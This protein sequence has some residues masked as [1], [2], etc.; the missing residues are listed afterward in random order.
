MEMRKLWWIAV[1]A[2]AIVVVLSSHW[3]SA[4]RQFQTRQAQAKVQYELAQRRL[5]ETRTEKGRREYVLEVIGLGVTVEKYRQGK[6]WDVLQKGTPYS[7]IREKDPHKY[8]WTGIDKDQTTG[9]RVGDTLENGA[10]ASPDCWGVPVF[11]AQPEIHN[12]ARVDGP[13]SPSPGLVA[14]AESNGMVSHLF[15]VG[16]RRY[17]ERP[18]RLIEEV[19][20]FFDANPDVPY[21]VLNSDDSSTTRNMFATIEKPR[22]D[23]YYI[24][25][26]PDASV[27]FLLARRERADAIRPFV[28]EDVSNEKSVEYLNS[29]SIS[30]RLFLAYLDLMKSLPRRD[31]ENTAARQPTIGEWLA[32]A[33]K[34]SA[35][36]ELR[37]NMPGSYRDL[38]FHHEHRVPYDWKPTPWFPV[39]WDKLRL[40]AFDG[41]PTMGFIHRPV[42]VNTSDE[43]GKPLAKRDQRKKALL[44]GL[45]EALL[46]LPEAERT[47]APARVIAGTNNNVEQ[48]LALEGML[49][50][51]AELGGPSIDSGKLDQFTNTDRRLGNT[52]AATWFVQMGIGVMG[53]YRAGGVSAAINLRDPHEASIVLISPPSEEKRQAQQQSRGDIFKPRNSPDI[54]PANYAP[55]SK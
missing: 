10:W 6:L 12:K 48:L 47:A 43:H 38:V 51:Y 2:F 13:L 3:V 26:M 32:A 8:P 15:V 25:A 46:T 30:R 35:R 27:L 22:E 36:P 34:F 28:F 9:S 19:F 20:A 18:D 39:P 53:S 5:A 37:G 1:P 33:A 44:A 45:Q 16:P 11:N 7:E 4:S 23:G 40:D 17:G 50:D 55:P 49:H 21:V 24:P 29:E 52:G 41:L 42:F 54:D 31:P 14:G